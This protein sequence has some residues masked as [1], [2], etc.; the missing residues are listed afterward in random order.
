MIGGEAVIRGMPM[1]RYVLAGILAVFALLTTRAIGSSG[2]WL[3]QQ[4]SPPS[5]VRLNADSLGTL[6]I[7]KAGQIVKRQ[8]ASGVP[9]TGDFTGNGNGNWSTIAP[10]DTGSTTVFPNGSQSSGF[11]TTSPF[12]DISPA[13]GDISPIDPNIVQPGVTR[14]TPLPGDL[15]DDDLESIPALW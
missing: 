15:V 1:N 9:S 6:P 8:G 5:R 11:T 13:T 14:P 2:Q 4:S 10:T 3:G 7:D 12:G